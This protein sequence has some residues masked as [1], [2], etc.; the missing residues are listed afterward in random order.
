MSALL[1]QTRMYASQPDY[2]LAVVYTTGPHGS[3]SATVRQQA[4]IEMTSVL[5]NWLQ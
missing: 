3:I 5:Q 4:M 1:T 2:N